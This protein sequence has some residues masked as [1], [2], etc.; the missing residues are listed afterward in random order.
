MAG[1]TSLTYQELRRY[2]RQLAL[3]EVGLGG[4]Q[5]LK[6]ASVLIVGA[7]GLGS[8]LALYLAA[9][10][11]GQLG[12]MDDD[13]VELSNL[14]RQV[15]HSTSSLGQ[16]KVVSAH[17]RVRNLNPEIAV[18]ALPYR[19]SAA[20]ALEIVDRFDIVADGTD[21]FNARYLINDACKLT[22]TPNVYGS[23]Y[24]FEGQV[25]VFCLEEGPCYRCLYPTPP[26]DHLVPSCAEGGV[27]G[28]L[29]G[30]IGCLQAA[31]VL[32][33]LLGV[34]SPLVG[35][36]L[37]MDVLGTT[38]QELTIRRDPDCALCGRAPS[39][40][41]LHASEASCAI[42]GVALLEIS[43]QSFRR[44]REGPT[45]PL[46]LDVRNAYEAEIVSLG[47]DMLIPLAEL[48]VRVHELMPYR[49]RKIVAYCRSGVRSGKAVRMLLDAG[50]AHA[51]NLAGGILAW[52]REV[53]PDLPAY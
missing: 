47:A 17:A 22:G 19:L 20:N 52:H 2:S 45:P 50:F 31:E 46:V 27:L 5:K 32:K 10:G 38:F 25:S 11:V 35:R 41:E 39:I 23:I 15:L 3:N 33:V 24:Q 44:M 18:E 51:V 1:A 21:T 26:P 12:I 42:G 6:Q 8:P 30:I 28:V 13:R 16:R 7:G 40:V 43:A 4:Q 53:D 29:P 49:E 37:V 34:G 36:M 14:H 48:R 9:A